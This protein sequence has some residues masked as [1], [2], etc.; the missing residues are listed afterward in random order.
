VLGQGVWDKLSGLEVMLGIVSGE[1][2]LPPI[3]RLMG[4]RPTEADEG[5]ATFTIPATRWVT[6]PAGFVEIGVTACLADFAL[7]SAIQTTVPAGT[8]FALTELRVQFVRPL[9]A[10]G[11][12]VSAKATVVHRGRGLAISRTEATKEDGKLV[13]IGNA[14]VLILPGRRADL[15]DASLGP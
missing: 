13:A 8:A 12:R 2:P 10:D 7:G 1:L 4:I 11:R 9:P 15:S 5:S 14:S 6:N 3:N